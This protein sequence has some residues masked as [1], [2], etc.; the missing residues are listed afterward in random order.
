MKQENFDHNNPQTFSF[1]PFKFCVQSIQNF[2]CKKPQRFSIHPISLAGAHEILLSQVFEFLLI[3]TVF[4]NIF[5]MSDDG[6]EMDSNN[7]IHPSFVII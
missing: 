1:K 3:S 5:Y 7:N 2:V 4:K 6:T